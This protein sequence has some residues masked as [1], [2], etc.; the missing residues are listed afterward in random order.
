MNIFVYG[1]VIILNSARVLKLKFSQSG[2]TAYNRFSGGIIITN[3]YSADA[4]RAFV[5]TQ[6]AYCLWNLT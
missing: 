6:F 3:L 2:V 4:S 1:V 5:R